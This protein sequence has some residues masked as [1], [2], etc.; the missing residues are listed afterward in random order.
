MLPPL[1]TTPPGRPGAETVPASRAASAQAPL[2]STA[3]LQRSNRKRIAATICPSETVTTESTSRLI[4]GQVSSPGIA[5]CWPSAIV[6]PTCTRTRSP[7]ASERLTSSD[8]S[9]STPITRVC[10][11]SA[12]I[13]VAQP[14][15][16]PPPPTGTSRMSGAPSSQQLERDRP[17]PGHHSGSSKGCTSVRP[18]SAASARTSASRSSR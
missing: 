18:R 4:T 15:I 12:A 16:R 13:T 14:E 11:A 2:G 5:V 7:A 1:I 9:G 17:L 6:G 10:G 8:A 3:S